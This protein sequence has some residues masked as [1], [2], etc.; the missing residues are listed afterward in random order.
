MRAD[1]RK[2]ARPLRVASV[3]VRVIVPVSKLTVYAE[4]DAVFVGRTL[5]LHVSC[6]PEDATEQG[7]TF[8]SNRESVA[9][10]TSSGRV[11]GVKRGSATI[12]VNS[13]DGNAKPRSR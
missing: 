8:E 13:V 1:R 11:V 10:V 2:P 5:Q 12:T 9:T 7:V 4:S 3:P 6:S